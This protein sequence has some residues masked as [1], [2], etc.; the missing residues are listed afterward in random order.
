[1]SSFQ[2]PGAIPVTHFNVT[3]TASWV[4]S[5]RLNYGSF[6]CDTIIVGSLNQLR[7]TLIGARQADRVKILSDSFLRICNQVEFKAKLQ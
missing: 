5:P 6:H 7:I 2:L 1:M 4:G 3:I